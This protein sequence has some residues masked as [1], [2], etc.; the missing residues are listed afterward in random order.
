[1]LTSTSDVTDRNQSV[2]LH[3]SICAS[4]PAIAG[5]VQGVMVL[6]DT[7]IQDMTLEQ[8]LAVTKPKVEGSIYLNEIFQQNTLDFFVFFSSASSVIGNHGQAN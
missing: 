1:M 7:A 5:V 4:M 2:A 8:L 3:N 6:R